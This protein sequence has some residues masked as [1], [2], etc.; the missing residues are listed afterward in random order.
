M[1]NVTH[2]LRPLDMGCHSDTG[3]S[4][5]PRNLY[6]QKIYG[7]SFEFDYRPSPGP[8]RT[9]A[10][11]RPDGSGWLSAS[12]GVG[13]TDARITGDGHTALHGQASVNLTC[14]GTGGRA[15]VA[16]R[17]LGNEGLYL[18]AKKPYEGYLFVQAAKAVRITVSLESWSAGRA[19]LVLA[20]STLA[21]GGGNYTRLNFSLTPN[22]SAACI[23]LI[24]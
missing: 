17:G 18:E 16:N 15:A 5:Q 21:F 20:S 10:G 11:W 12:V 23:G 9:G 13:N 24:P 3:Y 2:R 1:A 8:K 19:P 4:H 7:S 6:A 14:G 22:A